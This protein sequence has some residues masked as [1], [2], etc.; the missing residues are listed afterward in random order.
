MSPLTKSLKQLLILRLK[1]NQSIFSV[2]FLMLHVTS[3]VIG[4]VQYLFENQDGCHVLCTTCIS[5]FKPFP[6]R[7]IIENVEDKTKMV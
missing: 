4:I 7:L 6:G 5:N 1:T 2:I 3:Y